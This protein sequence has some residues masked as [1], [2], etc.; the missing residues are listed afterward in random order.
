M[1]PRTEPPPLPDIE[2]NMLPEGE[3]AL[4]VLMRDCN[5]VQALEGDLDTVHVAFLH[6]GHRR[7]ADAQPGTFNYYGLKQRAARFVTLETEYGVSYGAYR[8]AEADSQYWRIAHFLFPFYSMVPTGVLGVQK[9][10]RAWVPMDDEHTIFFHMSDPLSRGEGPRPGAGSQEAERRRATTAMAASAMA[11]VEPNTSDWLGRYRNAANAG[12]DYLI[13][14][15][16]QRE[17]NFTGMP[18]I[19]TEDQAVT[20]SMGAIYARTREHLGVSDAM[21]IRMRRSLINA[22]KALRDDGTLPPA[23]DSPAAYRQRSGG[24]VLPRSADWWQATSELRK[25]FATHPALATAG[26]GG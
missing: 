2:A 4:N 1:G 17:R 24:V 12:N 15:E 26:G 20:E 16:K 7:M 5:W 14:R 11:Q 18:N 13:D 23:V 3:Y 19:T 25:A 8:D 22:A 10:A 9:I 21:I 6:G